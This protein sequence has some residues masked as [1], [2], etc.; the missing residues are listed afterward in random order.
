[1]RIVMF[2]H[3]LVS[4]WN[5]GN[6]HFL[7]GV[8]TELLARGHDVLIFEP[9]DSWSRLNLVSEHGDKPIRRF[10]EAYPMLKSSPYQPDTLNLD[11]ALDEIGRASRRERK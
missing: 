10:H 11:E 2:Y 1:M 3:T 9:K 8:A 4:D 5:H 7:R 6:A